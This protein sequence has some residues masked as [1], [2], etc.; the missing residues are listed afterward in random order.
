ML[1]NEM[2]WQE[3]PGPTPTPGDLG[4]PWASRLPEFIEVT[5]TF[6]CEQSSAWPVLVPTDRKRFEPSR[7]T[8]TSLSRMENG[9]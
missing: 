2:V 8:I 4:A 7:I 5:V 6:D 9:V 1:I 3:S